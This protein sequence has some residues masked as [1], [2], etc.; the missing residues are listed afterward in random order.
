MTRSPVDPTTDNAEPEAQ[1]DLPP[2]LRP[3]LAR[4]GIHRLADCLTHFPLRYVDE[5]REKTLD[6]LIPGESVAVTGR[7][8]AAE[9]RFK[10]RRM[11][12]VRLMPTAATAGA[13]LAPTL[14][15]R[16]FNTWPGIASAYAIGREVRVFG[17]VREGRSGL[18]MI[19]PKLLPP[20]PRLP[21]AQSAAQPTDVQDGDT[22]TTG[23]ARTVGE[24][25]PIYPSTAGLPQQALRTLVAKARKVP[26]W[27]RE[28]LPEQVRR[29]LGLPDWATTLATLHSPPA[30][31]DVAALES[32]AHSAW[33]RVKFEEL[34]AQQ[35]ALARVRRERARERA[36]ALRANGRLVETLTTALPFRLTAP[37]VRAVAEIRRDLERPTPMSRL[38]QGDVG[39]GKTIVAALAAL[40]AVEAG[41]QVAFMA[42]TELL[43]EQHYRKLAHW[44]AALLSGTHAPVNLVWL[45][46]SQTA[47]QKRVARAAC[48]EGHAQIAVGTHALFQK[49]VRFA[50]LGLIVVDEQHRFGVAQRL[51]LRERGEGELVPHT[52]MMSATP[53]PRSLAMSYYA[54]LDVSVI[55][56]LPS[57]RQPI[58]TRLVSAARR[59]ELIGHVG[60]A[61]AAG[62]Q[63]YWVCPLIEESEALEVALKD[64][65]ALAAELHEALPEVT[66]ALLHGRLPP[67]E[68]EAIMQAF[69]A[70]RVQLLV[71]TTVIE[72]GVDVPN[73]S[74]MVIEHAERFGLAQLH[75]LRGRVGRGSAASTCVLVYHEPLS[76]TAKARLKVVYESTDGFEIAREDLRIRG[77]GEL[78]GPRQSGLPCLRYADLE[79]DLDLLEA[80]RNLRSEIESNPGFDA[81]ALL[82][83]WVREG[84]DYAKG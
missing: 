12:E 6:G 5:T 44:L 34:L 58:R 84:L 20:A 38:L 24:L 16:F 83:R 8:A 29:V 13:G 2:G 59:D 40:T 1:T 11:F 50:Q 10:P 73:A 19:H 26:A 54:D 62:A 23:P 71:A 78:L 35:V 79:T 33:R 68:K 27:Q 63:A 42:P 52:L 66:I 55:D 25:T 32:R 21:R 3:Q 80:A 76:E 30:D 70:G 81:E 9:F 37:Q 60:R 51:S 56:E 75:Q 7:V 65:T 67:A 46:G 31:I 57:G 18:E 64:A 43:A 17:E 39:S 61:L 28:L 49:G 53:I 36:P 4:L 77:P 41:A 69:I 22:A 72:V 15:L 47:A 45:S 48:A 82:A 74:W 14:S